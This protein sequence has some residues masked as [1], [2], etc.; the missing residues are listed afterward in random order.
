MTDGTHASSGNQPVVDIPDEEEAIEE[1][2]Q[3]EVT[4][5]KNLASLEAGPVDV[6][7]EGRICT[8]VVHEET[9]LEDITNS[10]SDNGGNSISPVRC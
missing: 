1:N 2:A 9:G 5:N 6:P 8:I 7:N 3:M 4:E 10:P